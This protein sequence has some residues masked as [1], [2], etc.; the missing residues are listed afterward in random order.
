M[1]ALAANLILDMIE[2]QH[3]VDEVD[4]VVVTPRLV[5]RQTT[6]PAPAAVGSIG[7]EEASR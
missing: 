6:G 3:R 1:G 2:G 7:R 4:D 5:V